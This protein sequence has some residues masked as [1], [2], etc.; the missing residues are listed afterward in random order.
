MSTIY[1]IHPISPGAQL[2][3][4][5]ILANSESLSN[6][7][8]KYGPT[9]TRYAEAVP[10][11]LTAFFTPRA[12][13]GYI[14]PHIQ[15][16]WNELKENLDAG[17]DTILCASTIARGAHQ[18][19]HDLLTKNVDLSR[20]SVKSLFILTHPVVRLEQIYRS[21]A[22]KQAEKSSR[23]YFENFRK[24]PT[25]L[26]DLREKYG[27]DSFH[28]LLTPQSSAVASLDNDLLA[29]LSGFINATLEMPDELL[30]LPL[31]LRSRIARRL[32]NFSE[33]RW[34]SW[35]ALDEDNFKNAILE[36]DSG[37]P[38]DMLS[39]PETRGHFAREAAA[40]IA[41]LEDSIGQP[42]ILSAPEPLLNQAQA[43]ALPEIPQ[44]SLEKFSS[45]L[46]AENRVALGRRLQ[47]DIVLL[48]PQQK[49]ILE[50]LKDDFN[51]IGDTE[52][53]VE[54][55]VLTMTYNHEKYIAE[56]MDSVLAQQCAFPVRHLVLDHHSDDRTPE[57][58]AEYAKKYPSIQPVLLSR[59]VA[60]ENVKGLFERCRTRY[61]AL[62]D[63]DDFFTEPHK[64]QKQ[65]DFLEAHPE[66]SLSFHPVLAVFDNGRKPE[67]F[68]PVS[69]LPKRKSGAFYLADLMK[70]N[71]IQTNS[72]VYR[73]RF[74]DG[75][76]AWFHANLCPGDW[77]WHILHAETGKI[78]FI[79]EVMS[80]YRRHSQALYADAW[81]PSSET[82][83]AKMGMSELYTY[84][85]INEH[86]KGRYYR[87][88]SLLA[89]AV[90]SD[91][92]KLSLDG[93][94]QLLDLAVE[95][96]PDFARDFL[97]KLNLGD[98][99]QNNMDTK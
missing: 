15:R 40:T 3:S 13:D 49:K 48:N 45:L 5:C 50:F 65:V 51:H 57:I 78:G 12:A 70:T 41:A 54:L 9:D 55:T 14:P 21:Y 80:A 83:R 62:C 94:S 34:N 16:Q 29:G 8:I 77:Y 63:G 17:I 18:S 23:G 74:T 88:L 22:P 58:V 20:H 59:R 64:L 46:N 71:F 52:A 84:K 82:L 39:P 75:L 76:P 31:R 24:L 73:W 43:Q 32:L 66:Y 47:N 44:E 98:T 91:F 86:F 36:I 89:S 6:K 10:T 99:A 96:Y 37:L 38:E 25:L 87:D 27:A 4:A 90:F 1:N 92:V 79:S 42:G 81:R 33:A 30:L 19:F 7:K 28:L 56:C 95:K 11:Q 97:R 35:P 60:G 26:E 2:I 72:A 67:V 93:D 68:P 69:V 53:P 61:A 85:V